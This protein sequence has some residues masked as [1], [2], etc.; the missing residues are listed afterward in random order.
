[1]SKKKYYAVRKGTNTGIFESWAECQ[2]AVKG[3]SKPEYKSFSTLAEAE[4]F[5]HEETQETKSEQEPQNQPPGLLV[6]YVDGSYDDSLRTYSFG[7]ILLTPDGNMIKK[8]GNG[9]NP[10]SLAIRNVAGEMLGAMYAV[11]W[12]MVNGYTQIDIRYDYA[13]IEKW[14]TGEWKAKNELTKKYAASM[15]KWSASISISFKKIAAHTNNKYNEEADLLAKAALTEANG[16][17]P[18][19]QEKEE[20]R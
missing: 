12:A 4:S 10:D 2:D 8:C 7:C 17:P 6:A 19:R 18:I 9:N 5:I 13:G 16:I 20:Q 11:R 3:F 14:V 1:M 15:N